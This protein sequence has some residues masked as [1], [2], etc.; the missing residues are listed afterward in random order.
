MNE[1]ELVEVI[2]MKTLTDSETG[3][4]H[5]LSVPLTQAVTAE[6]KE[7]FAGKEKIA[8]K[9]SAISEE[10]LAVVEGPCFFDNRKE[11]ISARVFGT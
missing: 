9:C 4:K 2:H 6:D 5:L 7:R 10:I 1:M 3:E 8:L 11:E